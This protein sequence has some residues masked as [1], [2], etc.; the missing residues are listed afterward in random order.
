M[1]ESTVIL[2]VWICAAEGATLPAGAWPVADFGPIAGTQSAAAAEIEIKQRNGFLIRAR[3]FL[4]VFL[5]VPR[6]FQITRIQVECCGYPRF[7][8][9]VTSLATK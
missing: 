7:D 8:K 5:D 6:A 4:P 1:V 9:S 3:C 2:S